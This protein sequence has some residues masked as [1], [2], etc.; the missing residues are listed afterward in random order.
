[1]SPEELYN[2]NR[3]FYAEDW[4]VTLLEWH[5]L[6]HE[7]KSAWAAC[8]MEYNLKALEDREDDND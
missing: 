5:D 4:G 3:T 1:M 7:Q 8:A 2:A 6:N